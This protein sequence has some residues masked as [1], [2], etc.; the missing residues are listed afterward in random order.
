MKYQ[1]ATMLGALVLVGATV[2]PVSAS[3][4]QHE[5]YPETY[6]AYEHFD[7]GESF[8]VTWAG[9]FH[10]VRQG[11][12]RLVMA[13]GGQQPGE[14]HV[15]GVIDGSVELIPDDAGLP[16]YS[17]V[18]REKVN[19]VVTAFTDEGDVE[20]VSQY[21]LPGTLRGTDGST[22]DLRLSGKFTMNPNGVV[23]VS[24]DTFT[25]E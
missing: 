10:E 8:C 3:G 6:D 13:P 4:A 1:P 9:T 17:G 7:A 25:C 12:Y 23:V 11:G 18:Y 21:R 16:R 19:G 15:N 20:R 5:F 24:R 22:L 14:L 2:A